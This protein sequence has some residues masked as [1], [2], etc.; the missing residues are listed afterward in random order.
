L[1][2][3]AHWLFRR[4]EELQGPDGF[5]MPRMTLLNA[6]DQYVAVD[7]NGHAS[8]PPI[9][10]F[11]AHVVK[12]ENRQVSR[13][14]ACPVAEGLGFFAARQW[15]RG[16]RCGRASLAFENILDEALY[17]HADSARMSGQFRFKFRPDVYGHTGNA[18]I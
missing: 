10:V 1:K 18:S 5:L 2:K 3:Y 17:G 6:E 4:Q 8:I 9:E 15:V 11:T 7:E 12:S 16:I 13:K 14:T